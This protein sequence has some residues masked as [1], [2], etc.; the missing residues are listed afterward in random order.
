VVSKPSPSLFSSEVPGLYQAHLQHLLASGISVEVIKERG[1]RTISYPQE[2]EALGF[3]QFSKKFS[4]GILMPLHA[5]D[6]SEAGHVY[7]ADVP[8]FDRKKQR[9][10][11][12]ENVPGS[13]V[14][15]DMPMRCVPNARNPS[16]DLWITE[17]AKKAD[18]L[19]SHGA[20]SI[21]LNGVWGFKGKNEFGATSL[22]ADFDLVAWKGRTVYL[23]YDSDLES[24]IIRQVRQALQRLREILTHKGARVLIVILP[25]LE[26]GKKTGVDD[27]LAAGYSLDELRSLA[28]DKVPDASQEAAGTPGQNALGSWR[29]DDWGLYSRDATGAET[30][31]LRIP[32]RPVEVLVT[33]DERQVLHMLVTIRGSPRHTYLDDAWVG[34]RSSDASREL[35]EAAG[36]AVS[37]KEA[38]VLQ[39]FVAEALRASVFPE[40]RAYRT[41]GWHGDRLCVPSLDDTIMI[42]SPGFD[43]LLDGYQMT[44]C[45]EKCA[46][47]A[48]QH[49][50]ELALQN[51]TIYVAEGVGLAAPLLKHLPR[52]QYIS[53]LIHIHA[54]GTGT[55]KTT[56]IDLGA[57]TNGNPSQL[58]RTWDSTKVG[59]EL[60]LGTLRNMSVFLNEL[61]DAKFG[62]P[63]EVVMMLAEEKGRTRGNSAGGLRPTYEWRTMVL[64]SGN[65][66]IAQGSA[67][68]A[69]RVISI[70]AALSDETIALELQKVSR[71]YF[72]WPL[73]WCAPLYKMPGLMERLDQIAPCYERLYSG[74]LSPLKPQAR[75][76]AVIELG[77]RMLLAI[78]GMDEASAHT[79][80]LKVAEL[81]VL[82][83]QS[84]GIDYVTKLVGL[85]REAVARDPGGF[86]V[87][88]SEKPRQGNK[89]RVFYDRGEDQDWT[90][91]AILPGV[92]QE[93]VQKAGGIPDLTGVLIEARDRGVLQ[94]SQDKSRLQKQIR[95]RGNQAYCYVFDLSTGEDAD[96]GD[97]GGDNGGDSFERDFRACNHQPVFVTTCH[98][99][100]IPPF[101]YI[102]NRNIG[103]DGGDVVTKEKNTI[104]NTNNSV[105]TLVTTGGD[106]STSSEPTSSSLKSN[107]T[108]EV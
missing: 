17:G 79:G 85:V 76:W 37:A 68:H 94:T 30:L 65:S 69:R 27:Y 101:I 47:E 46:A 107:G 108:L 53:S 70:P 34:K 61:A 29:W 75:S 67:H 55:G 99:Q 5:P 50:N 92:L 11:K 84:E 1:Y 25:V 20:C 44:K 93:L 60:F 81:S 31:K 57:A 4:S 33:P 7:R 73:K 103:G 8:R 58:V 88:S 66:P 13:Q 106:R 6:R 10:I 9:H 26:Q 97:N 45:D 19:A 54:P 74:E 48:W 83:R 95:I 62:T 36:I 41:L 78:L 64:S 28:T 39:Q 72:G 102:K 35:A 22:L 98:H 56:L 12:Y 91:A 24:R 38:Y 59:V 21:N 3:S 16:V 49:V 86:G 40:K 43:W 71:Q 32:L 104:K 18:A 77:A 15:A 2:L 82:R 96:G 90:R 80:V 63:P 87:D 105:T 42:P 23:A 14:R 51:P 89:G 100:K 52:T